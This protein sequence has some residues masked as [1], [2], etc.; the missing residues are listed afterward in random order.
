MFDIK[1]KDIV[2]ATGGRL[3]S[4]DENV[5]IDDVCTDSRE[6][7]PGDLFIPLLGEKVDAH[8]YIESVMEVAA[9]TLTSQHRGVVISDKPYIA[10]Y[11]TQK[12]L[13]DIG[14]FIRNKF[15]IPIIGVTGSVGKTTTREMISAALNECVNA[16]QTEKNYNS[17]VGVPIALSR[18]TKDAEIAVLE[19]GMSDFGQMDTLSGLVRPDICVVTMIGVA[20]IEYLKTQ[21]N[22][23]DEKLSIVNHMNPDGVLFLNG[24]DPMLAE[25]KGET[26]VNT[27]LFGTTDDCEYRAENIHM[28]NYKYAYDYVHGDV[29]IPVVINALGRHNVSNSLV[30]MA[31]A[32]Y[33]GF[34]L[35]QAAEGFAHFKGSRQKLIDIPGKYT[36]ID[37]TYNASP[38]SMKAAIDVIAEL[39]SNGKK[40]IVL[41]DMFELGDNSERFHYQIGE[42]IADKAID[43]LVVVGE[44]AQHIM[45]A[46]KDKDSKL[47]CTTLKDTEEVALYLM[48]A[49]RAGDIVLL[50]AS[51]GMHLNR[52]VEN[53]R[54]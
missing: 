54:G 11:D 38:D 43:E 45:K 9:A 6:I 46:V 39:E 24:D 7:K 15:D 33:M 16:Y 4:G 19:M 27:L 31:I 48:S 26:G 37:D 50:K 23:R 12:A 22:I 10:V 32:D 13:Q 29:R 2:E 18:I 17:Q 49:M 52:I 51:N 8:I 35:N 28:T 42:Y 25:V 21:E 36:I 5:V 34:D 41:G 53:M 3:L 44:L 1:V 20:H 30:G 40:F 47:H 14:A